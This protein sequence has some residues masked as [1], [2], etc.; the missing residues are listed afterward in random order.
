M[1]VLLL[2]MMC[3]CVC[4]CVCVCLC[5][6][7]CVCVHAC[8]CACAVPY[9]LDIS[10]HSSCPWCRWALKYSQRPAP[11][12]KLRAGCV[13]TG[14]YVCMYIGTNCVSSV[15]THAHTQLS[16][17]NCVQNAKQKFVRS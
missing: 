10:Y 5:L 8:V 11:A 3:A 1:F 2:H 9:T 13:C 15:H 17:V 4:V 16:L 7:L 6:C 12:P 14:M